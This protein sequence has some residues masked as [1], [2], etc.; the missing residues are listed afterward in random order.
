MLEIADNLETDGAAKV[1][2]D[3]M[4]DALSSAALSDDESDLNYTSYRRTDA[5]YSR[6]CGKHMQFDLADSDTGLRCFE[7]IPAFCLQDAMSKRGGIDRLVGTI[8]DYI[9]AEM[10]FKY[11]LMEATGMTPSVYKRFI[12]GQV[13]G[14][15]YSSWA[16]HMFSNSPHMWYAKLLHH[17]FLSNFASHYLNQVCETIEASENMIE[18]EKEY[19]TCFHVL[20][21]DQ[22]RYLAELHLADLEENFHIIN[23]VI[24]DAYF[25][26]AGD[27]NPYFDGYV[28]LQDNAILMNMTTYTAFFDTLREFMYVVYLLDL[29]HNSPETMTSEQVDFLEGFDE[30]DCADERIDIY[31]MIVTGAKKTG[32][33]IA[34]P[35]GSLD[36]TVTNLESL[37]KSIDFFETKSFSDWW[38][39][40]TFAYYERLSKVFHEG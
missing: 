10:T 21:L 5:V 38:Y 3:K 34:C 39:D 22:Q 16:D 17:I 13:D 36:E 30:D 1:R 20:S 2:F 24:D 26:R 28:A 18:L 29:K 37:L 33:Y 35:G 4:L 14:Y 15:T 8:R 11:K 6:S 19:A 12:I 40:D 7:D 27:L 31:G 25:D 9:D 32:A 23:G